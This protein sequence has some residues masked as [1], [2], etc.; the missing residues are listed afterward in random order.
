MG[1]CTSRHIFLY[2]GLHSTRHLRALF[3]RLF[4]SF[5][6][7]KNEL[8]TTFAFMKTFNRWLFSFSNFV[9]VLINW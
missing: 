5:F 7:A 1:K 8:V 6:F 2:G 9:I 4:G 3:Y